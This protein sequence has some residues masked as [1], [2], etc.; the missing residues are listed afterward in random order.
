MSRRDAIE[1]RRLGPE[2]LAVLTS[3]GPDVF[4]GPVREDQARAFLGDR[5]HEIVAALEGERIV[6]FAAGTVLLQPDKLP[7]F[8]INEV[9]VVEDRRGRGIATA[10]MKRIIEVAVDRGCSHAWLTT[11]MDNAA[12]RALYR[13]WG[14]QEEEH[15]VY[16]GWEDLKDG[17]PWQGGGVAG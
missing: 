13:R 8:Y 15:L 16:Y 14:A 2:D 5:N 1:I 9:G 6:G 3:A 10:L 11:E 4:D 7:Q 17:V 12:A